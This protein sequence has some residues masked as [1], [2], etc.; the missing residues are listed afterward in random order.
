M[1]TGT[2]NGNLEACLQLS[3]HSPDG[4]QLRIQA[5]IDTGFAGCLFVPREVVDRLGLP[6]IG[7]VIGILAD[8]SEAQL[9][10][11][12]GVIEWNGRQREIDV[13]AGDGE[14]LVGTEMLRNHSVNIVMAPGGEVIIRS[15][16][17]R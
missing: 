1:I 6:S 10:R 14:P 9:D 11:H 7:T 5:V 4:R 16:R 2:V 15:R 13:L 12:L 3:L 8:E 17:D